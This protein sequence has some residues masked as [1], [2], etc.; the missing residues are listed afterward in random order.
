MNKVSLGDKKHGI[1]NCLVDKS[2]PVQSW[3]TQSFVYFDL[4]EK[5]GATCLILLSSIVDCSLL[6]Q[7]V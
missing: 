6:E 2:N 4:V 3:H 7:L 1:N 5:S